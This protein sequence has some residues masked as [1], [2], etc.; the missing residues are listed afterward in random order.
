MLLNELIAKETAARGVPLA[1]LLKKKTLAQMLS[2][3]FCDT[4]KGTFLLN[5][6]F[7]TKKKK[8]LVFLDFETLLPFWIHFYNFKLFHW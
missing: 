1:S 7:C 8:L 5:Q 3:E 6:C 4:F 2:C